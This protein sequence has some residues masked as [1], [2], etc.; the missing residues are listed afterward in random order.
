M[1]FRR[2]AL[3]ATLTG[4]SAGLMTLAISLA[5]G[6]ICIREV[7]RMRYP[8]KPYG[9]E[10]YESFGD[11][12]LAWH[13]FLLAMSFWFLV[14]VVLSIMIGGYFKE[15]SLQRFRATNYK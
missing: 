8:D 3:Q 12:M 11:A 2:Q 5:L 15:K 4:W 7:S 13:E 14:T 10:A 9:T 6:F 1:D